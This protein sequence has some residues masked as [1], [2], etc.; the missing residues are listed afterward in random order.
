MATPES[1]VKAQV[2]KIL[3]AHAPDIWYFM[4]IP[5]YNRGVPD[6]VAC[7][8]GQFVGIECKAGNNKPTGIQ[9]LTMDRIKAAGGDCWVINEDNID[10]FRFWLECLC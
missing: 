3:D 4:P 9:T 6:I 1:R 5:L 2:K 10:E 8:L 7:I